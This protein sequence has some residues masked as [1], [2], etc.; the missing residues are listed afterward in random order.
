M[1][2][3]D[4]ILIMYYNFYMLNSI[5]PQ[6]NPTSSLSKSEAKGI[7]S[8]SF[9]G[10]ILVL[11][12]AILAVS[13][14][15]TLNLNQN[16]GIENE[17]SEKVEIPEAFGDQENQ[18]VDGLPNGWSDKRFDRCGVVIPIPSVD[19][20]LSADG[21][22]RSWGV[23]DSFEIMSGGFDESELSVGFYSYDNLGQLLGGEILTYDKFVIDCIDNEQGLDL[24]ESFQVFLESVQGENEEMKGGNGDNTEAN[25]YIERVEDTSIFGVDAIKFNIG[26]Y[27][28]GE[29]ELEQLFF[30]LN[31]KVYRVGVSVG[32]YEE[33][34]NQVLAEVTFF[35]KD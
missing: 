26:G 9:A 24:E 16:N 8:K 7:I 19:S 5:E 12:I 25:I 10:I 2:R 30:V 34:I 14:V 28:F 1:I 13:V 29:L 32:S 17:A 6:E 22:T 4:S 3:S 20:E 15:I 31:D 21:V 33:I 18:V 11:L 23:V 27:S 35:N